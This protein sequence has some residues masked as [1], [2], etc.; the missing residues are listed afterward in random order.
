MRDVILKKVWEHGATLQDIPDD[1]L[2]SMV[3]T[4]GAL[5]VDLRSELDRR[6]YQQAGG[7]DLTA[8]ERVVR[9]GTEATDEDTRL[10]LELGVRYAT[11]CVCQHVVVYSDSPIQTPIILACCMNEGECPD[12]IAGPGQEHGMEIHP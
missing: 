12:C 9:Y 7:F 4:L 10:A 3:G 5:Y 1:I 11:R 2:A 8:E 6:R